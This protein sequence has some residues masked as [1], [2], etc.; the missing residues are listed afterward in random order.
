MMA[1]KRKVERFWARYAGSVAF[2]AIIIVGC[3]GFARIEN[4]RYESCVGGN[5]LREGLRQA[6]EQNIATTEALTPDL[7]PGLTVEEFNLLKR[8]S[9]ERAEEHIA[10]NFADRPCGTKISLP[11]TGG[12]VVIG[13][14][15]LAF[16]P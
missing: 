7:L 13:G 5:L 3:I 4:A 2:I 10:K 9:V 8:E 12:A 14:N 11:L 15:S 6:E 16:G 1:R